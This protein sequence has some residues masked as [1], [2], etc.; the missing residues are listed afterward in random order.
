MLRLESV[1]GG[2]CT[3]AP[4]QL[5]STMAAAVLPPVTISSIPTA[6]P[7]ADDMAAALAK[8]RL[9]SFR[10]NQLEAVTALLQGTASTSKHTR[11]CVH[12]YEVMCSCGE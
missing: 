3:T 2:P 4:L 12:D 5:P 10:P 9:S 8:F 1:G 11:H 7:S 6:A